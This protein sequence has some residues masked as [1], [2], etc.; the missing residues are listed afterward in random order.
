MEELEW[1]EGVKG[2]VAGRGG[3]QAVCPPTSKWQVGRQVD[4]QVGD[5][6]E[7]QRKTGYYTITES[8]KPKAWSVTATV[9]ETKIQ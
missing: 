8:S 5:D 4:W 7:T 3:S 6:P 1:A 9:V 2:S